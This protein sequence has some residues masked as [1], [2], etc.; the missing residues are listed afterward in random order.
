MPALDRVIVI[1]DDR[2]ADT[3]G[4]DDLSTADP[5]GY[6]PPVVDPDAVSLLVYTSGTTAD[7]KGVQH[8]HNT[9]L[10]ENE[11]N[12]AM[13]GVVAGDVSLA[14][15]PAGHIAGV[16]NLL[17]L[18]VSGLSSVVLDTFEPTLA[19]RLVAEHRAVSSAGA[20]FYLQTM[21]DAAAEE[22]LDLSSL[23]NYMVGAASVPPQLVED[24]DRAGVIAYRAYGSSE[25]PV[26]TTGVSEDPLEARA[27]TDGRLT[28]GNEVRIVDDDGTDLAVG[29]DGEI[30]C[31][32]PEQF[33]GY[34]DASLDAET[35]RAGAWFATGD[36]GRMDDRGYLTITDRKKD[37]IIRGGENIASKEVEDILARHPAVAESAVVAM[38]DPRYGERV[39]AFVISRPGVAPLD[40]DT[41]RAHFADAGVAKQKTPERVVIVDELP[42][43]MSGKVKK[44]ELRRLL[45]K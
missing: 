27:T 22:G 25:H 18:T 44:F 28:A 6:V 14:A 37:V 34:R 36:I 39:C 42:R 26:L 16:L 30:W 9:L 10:A 35:F 11:I 45:A 5:S 23:R 1:G 31:R 17:R 20:P 19:A 7:P 38:P 21:L 33:V 41:V 2:P 3:I 32:G 43:G 13:T 15:F 8:T 12:G 24:A 40:L 29:H 4:W